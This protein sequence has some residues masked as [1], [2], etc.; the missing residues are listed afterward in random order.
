MLELGI[1]GFDAIGR[2]VA[3]ELTG[4][5][6][7]RVASILVRPGTQPDVPDGAEAVTSVENLL[8]SSPALVAECAGQPAVEEFGEQVL[9]A[10]AD[11]ML[12]STGALADKA[13]HGRLEA[14]A[15]AGGSRMLLPVGATAG[16]DGLTAL[17]ASGLRRVTYRSTKP[18]G[19][20]KGTKAEQ[21]VDLDALIE[22]TVFYEGSAR[23]AARGFPKNA[24][25]A[26]TVALAGI[27]LDRT[28]VELVADPTATGNAGRIEA[29]GTLG[30]L[31]VETRGTPTDTNP[32]TS[33]VTAYSM[34]ASL[35]SRQSTLVLP[36]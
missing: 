34:V 35:E 27:G 4:S 18:P 7:Y 26:A 13:T 10:G 6:S 23:E 2:V 21:L 20:W 8:A 5:N 24:N 9:A 17:R 36:A 16:M 22:P 32:K 12:I 11:L 28:E 3:G 30:A 33:A 31:I 29:E 1:I 25:V 19:A 14:A 15:R